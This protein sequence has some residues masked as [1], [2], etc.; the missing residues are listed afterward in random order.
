MWPARHSSSA[1]IR[2]EADLWSAV[3]QVIFRPADAKLVNSL[4]GVSSPDS[5]T[6]APPLFAANYGA[7]PCGPHVTLRPPA[8]A[9][10]SP[11]FA[12]TSSNSTQ[13]T[14]GRLRRPRYPSSP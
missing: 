14:K 10:R 4:K 11:S 9:L 2:K 13:R 5:P 3:G 8:M 6:E 12:N 7:M 1:R